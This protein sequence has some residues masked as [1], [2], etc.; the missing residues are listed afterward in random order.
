MWPTRAAPDPR[1]GSRSACR[2]SGRSA[3]ELL[4]PEGHAEVREQRLALGIVA[5]GRADRDVEPRDLLDL[6]V[7]DLG[8]DDL[9]ADAEGVVPA[10]VERLRRHAL[11]VAHARQRHVHQAVVEL[12]HAVA[13]QGHRAAD[14]LALAQLEV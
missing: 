9:L 11:E 3:W 14:R 8:E 6:V 4:L 12:V 7:L 13:A 5:R 2:R 10:A 1:C